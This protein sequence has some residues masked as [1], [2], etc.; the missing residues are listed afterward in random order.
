M[1]AAEA[2][3][4]ELTRQWRSFA[5]I[6]DPSWSARTVT[7]S[8]TYDCWDEGWT[9]ENR[10]YCEGEWRVRT[11]AVSGSVYTID[12]EAT[13]GDDAGDLSDATD[14]PEDGGIAHAGETP[15]GDVNTDSMPDGGGC[16]CKVRRQGHGGRRGITLLA[17]AG[18]CVV[19]RRRRE[20]PLSSGCER[21]GQT[22][23]AGHLERATGRRRGWLKTPCGTAAP[24]ARRGALRWSRRSAGWRVT[25]A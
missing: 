25:V 20:E 7:R 17:P 15:D 19:R 10:D 2:R 14:P 1:R 24:S 5:W 22:S 23:L 12:G 3:H 4:V 18:A 9:G 13:E 16:G 11:P 8:A 21:Y 6:W